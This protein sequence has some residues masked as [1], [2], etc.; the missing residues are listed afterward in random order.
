MDDN[1]D[2]PTAFRY[3]FEQ[4]KRAIRGSDRHNTTAD[5]FVDPPPLRCCS[6]DLDDVE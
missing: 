5:D 4:L 2:I 1:G 3:R 6:D